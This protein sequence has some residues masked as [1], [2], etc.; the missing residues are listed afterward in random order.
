[1]VEDDSLG[2]VAGRELAFQGGEEFAQLAVAARADLLAEVAGI[3]GYGGQTR[4]IRFRGA[5]A[6]GPCRGSDYG[7]GASPRR[8][9]LMLTQAGP[10]LSGT[11]LA[12]VRIQPLSSSA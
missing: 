6:R 3:R 5:P 4:V 7:S 1:M 10:D 9:A 2:E 11:L 8:R 12:R